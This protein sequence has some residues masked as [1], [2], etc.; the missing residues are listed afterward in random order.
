MKRI[1]S[2]IGAL[3]FVVSMTIT[4]Q[5]QDAVVFGFFDAN[6]FAVVEF[7][8]GDVTSPTYLDFDTF[9]STNDDGSTADTEIL[10]FSGLG[11]SA[12]FLVDDDDG[13]SGFFSSLTFGAGAGA[14][15]HDGDNFSGEDGNLAAGDYTLVIGEFSTSPVPGGTFQDFVDQGDFGNEA[16]NFTL[17]I[18]TND[19]SFQ[20]AAVPEPASGL[21]LV[22]GMLG[23]LV[24]RRR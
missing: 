15:V 23:L 22:G 1:K 10:L 6:E 20:L 19:A 2:L 24:R 3:A 17:N 8:T 4:A 18:F 21:L 9:G 11:P 16:V 12:T 13:A 14:G 7:S 5:A